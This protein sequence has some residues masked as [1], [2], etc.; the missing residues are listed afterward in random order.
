MK[1]NALHEA[2][3]ADPTSLISA[4]DPDRV[5]HSQRLSTG[6]FLTDSIPKLLLGLAIPTTIVMLAQIAISVAEVYYISALGTSVLAGAAL[7]FPLQMLMSTMSAGGFGNGVSSA[8]SRALGAQEHREIQKIITHSIVISLTLGLISFLI[9]FVGGRWIYS[10]LGGIDA[11]LNAAQEYSDIVFLGAIPLW[12]TNILSAVYRGLGNPLFPAKITLVGAIFL[13]P[14]SPLLIFGLGPIPGLGV[15]GAGWA[16]F[17][18]YSVAASL[19]G[20]ALQRDH[21][22]GQPWKWEINKATFSRI[23]R[24]GIPSS[25]NAVQSGILVVIV[26]SMAAGL[27]VNALAAYGIASRLDALLVPL[28]FG[29]G[30][31]ALTA[32]GVNFSAG[33]SHRAHSVAWTAAG[34]AILISGLPALLLALAPSIWMSLFT[35]APDIILLG[36][37]YLHISALTFPLISASFIITFALQGAGHSFWPSTAV[38]LRLF[39]VS[40]LAYVSIHAFE[41]GLQALALANMAGSILYVTFCLLPMFKP[42]IWGTL[43]KNDRAH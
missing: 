19:L 9:M 35:N 17:I 16:L 30:S 13:I 32:T 25:L 22:A 31:A 21:F 7:V 42:S 34:I 6:S 8:V 33:K 41:L 28:L 26:T 18:Y 24:I 14:L 43:N 2:P 38:T 12:V 1:S 27:G 20:I 39:L 23:L 5:G 10:A 3:L 15:A 37:E 29:L 4:S 36:C 11:S 40:V